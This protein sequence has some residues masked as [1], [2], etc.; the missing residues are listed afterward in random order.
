M[1][2]RQKLTKKKYVANPT[3]ISSFFDSIT[4]YAKKTFH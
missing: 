3:T 1:D 4:P 2:P